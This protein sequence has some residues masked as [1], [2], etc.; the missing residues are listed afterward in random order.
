MYI[1]LITIGGG[2]GA[3]K[4]GRI[5]RNA[6]DRPATDLYL[7]LARAMGAPLMS[8][9]NSTGVIDEVLA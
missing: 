9:G 5:V 6:V 4:T 8:F 7:T 2:G 3:L 1:P